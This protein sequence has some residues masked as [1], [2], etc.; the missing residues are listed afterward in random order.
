ML[1]LR[2]LP[3]GLA[4]QVIRRTRGLDESARSMLELLAVAGRPVGLADLLAM[5]GRPLDD[6]RPI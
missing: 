5:S 4:E 3:E 2:R 1:R 6:L